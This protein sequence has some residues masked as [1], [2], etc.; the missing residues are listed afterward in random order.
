MGLISEYEPREDS[1]LWCH[2]EN[3]DE[4]RVMFGDVLEFLLS[5]LCG[6]TL[7]R[8]KIPFECFHG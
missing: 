2:L 4:F 1:L 5:F 3:P 7:N 8:W 6:Q